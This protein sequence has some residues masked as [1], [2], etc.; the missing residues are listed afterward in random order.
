MEWQT[1]L[2]YSRN[3]Y[4]AAEFMVLGLQKRG[5]RVWFDVQQL[6]P[7]TDWQA[8]IR[9]GLEQ[10]ENVL[11]LASRSSLESPYV[12]REWRHALAAGRPVIVARLDSVR[13]PS[14][15]RDAPIVDCRQ[16]AAD[17]I[18]QVAYALENPGAR[19]PRRNWLIQSLPPHIRRAALGLVLTDAA[20]I[21]RVL[22]FAVLW[23]ALFSHANGVRWV[24]DQ[25]ALF[26]RKTFRFD[27][28]ISAASDI[29]FT[30]G[31][32]IALLAVLRALP[33]VRLFLL[34]R[35]HIGLIRPAVRQFTYWTLLFWMVI[36]AT[37][38][39]PPVSE[40]QT[41]TGF[42]PPDPVW[43]GLMGVVMVVVWLVEK[44]GRR[45][46]PDPTLAA[47][48]EWARFGTQSWTGTYGASL[49]PSFRK[50]ALSTAIRFQ[51]ISTPFDEP[52]MDILHAMIADSGGDVV[53]RGLPCDYTIVLLNAAASRSQIATALSGTQ[54]VVGIITTPF[55][56]PPEIEAIKNFQLIDFSKGDKE[57]LLANLRLL[58]A[59]SDELR[60]QL[61]AWL[62]P[63]N[64][65]RITPPSDI[66][67]L[68]TPFLSLLL[69][70]VATFVLSL[71]A[72]PTR[73][74][75]SVVLG[76]VS[77]ALLLLPVLRLHHGHIPP[78]PLLFGL[79]WLSI[80][81][82]GA[83]LA[84]I[85]QDSGFAG[86]L[87]RDFEIRR[88]ETGAAVMI[89]LALTWIVFRTRPRRITTSDAL[90]MPP[91][92]LPLRPALAWLG[93]ALFLMV[94]LMAG[95]NS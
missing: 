29:V 74:A 89:G 72:G 66:L 73:A 56:L 1:F 71:M 57:R 67:Q 42:T 70:G 94:M 20:H 44:V 59:P 92:P 52:Q 81:C 61:Q 75:P 41:Q 54:P 82:S 16:N 86:V 43:M 64:L 78:R 11:L 2:S 47:F 13:L 10:S 58:T 37:G 90:G 35:H 7:G 85:P 83:A 77:C 48:K 12:E 21:G 49:P 91:L 28:P 88:I 8:D 62:G 40:Q 38:Y 3:D 23:R 24:L 36:L 84:G 93:I 87:V 27:L 25:A 4:Q 55:V 50:T 63:V 17:S 34:L 9:N 60:S 5:L 14:D 51:I 31:I 30:L 79:A 32:L 15:L 69:L 80:V 68:F 19:L 33:V 39:I 46:L 53:A 76:G 22:L 45:W 95:G 6:E 18:E 26:A 65:R